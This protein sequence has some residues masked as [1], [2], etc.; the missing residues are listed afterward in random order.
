MTRAEQLF[1]GPDM[2]FYN[3]TTPHSD[4]IKRPNCSACGTP[5][6]LFGI[7]AERPGYELRT[8]VCPRCDRIETAVGT[9]V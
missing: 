7:E 8:F 1:T 6:N 9:T 3:P 4:S 5:T 2:T